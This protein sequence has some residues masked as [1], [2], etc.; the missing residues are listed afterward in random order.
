MD[1]TQVPI[2]ATYTRPDL[3][4][5]SASGSEVFDSMGRRYIDFLAGIAVV[6]VGHSHVEVVEVVKHQ[7]AR[8][9]HVS[10]LFWSDPARRLSQQLED[11]VGLGVKVFFA[12]SG[13]EA[14]ECAIKLARKWGYPRNRHKIICAENGFHG[15]TMGALAATGQPDKSKYFRPLLGGFEFGV[16]NDLASFE[17]LI[18][19]ETAAVLVEPIQGEGGVIPGTQEFLEG[20]REV[21]DRQEALLI[22]DEI[23]CGVGRTGH[24]W[25]F[26]GYGVVPDLFTSAKGLGNGFPIGACVAKEEIAAS[27]Q[28]GDHGSTF[29][30][31]PLVCAVASKVVELVN[32]GLIESVRE[33]GEALRGL[34]QAL[35]GVKEV[36]GAGLMLGVVLDRP[37]AKEIA[38]VALS[39]GLII[40]GVRPDTIRITPP[41]TI[42]DE[43]LREGVEILR[44]CLVSLK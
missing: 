39:K 8:L 7:A 29:G 21:C 38:Q 5:D 4:F 17:K 33:S 15:R 41:L 24:F 27:F 36:R 19:E 2:M 12:N 23:Q 32:S 18:D 30:G 43:L 44:K 6:S 3:V 26:Q 37:I 22:F 35:P 11:S 14:I 13:T 34:L 31:G 28:P 16:Y 40:N 10:N 42:S 20:L 1:L 25:G 9:I